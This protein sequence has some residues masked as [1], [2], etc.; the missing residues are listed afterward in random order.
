MD[1]TKI[2]IGFSKPREF[3][4]GA[5]AISWWMAAPYSHAY[6]RFESSDPLIPSNVYQAS[7]GMCHFQ[8]YE[9]FK[10]D[11]IPVLEYVIPVSAEVRRKTLIN[12]MNLAGE[13]YGYVELIKILSMDLG[14]YVGLQIKFDDSRGYICSELVG[15]LCTQDLDIHFDKPLHVLKP[16]DVEMALKNKYK[17]LQL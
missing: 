11:N 13:K 2:Y 7:H 16:V 14:N 10:K 6:I 9:N 3:K 17:L 5:K 15:T 4:I 8:T 1:G 12:C